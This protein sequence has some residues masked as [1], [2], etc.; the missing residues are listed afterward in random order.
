MAL[1]GKHDGVEVDISATNTRELLVRAT[2]MELL[3]RFSDEG[4]SFVWSDNN[5]DINAGDTIL[6][7]R[8]LGETVLLPIRILANPGNVQCTYSVGL[9]SLTTVATG[10]SITPVNM[11]QNL[12]SKAA[13]SVSFGDET[14][15]ADATLLFS[16][17]VGTTEDK[18]ID[19]RGIILGKNQYIQINQETEST[20]GR[21]NL[22]GVFIEELI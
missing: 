2:S 7:I 12:S 22:F 3:E 15:V 17:T 9:G 14:A 11:N 4:Q 13:D 20:S 5:A 21:M 16:F 1:K 6:F 8:N 10:T 18:E 19:L